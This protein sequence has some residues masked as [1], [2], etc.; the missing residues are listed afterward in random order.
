[1]S[2]EYMV[3]DENNI[4][5]ESTIAIVT[6]DDQCKSSNFEIFKSLKG[7]IG[8]DWFVG[9]TY[10][11]LQL[12]IGDQC[13]FSIASLYGFTVEWNGGKS[14]SDLMVNVSKER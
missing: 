11:C 5:P 14:S 12:L 2:L 8:R 7:M 3:N 4:I 9:H 6:E 13:E 10:N 1:M